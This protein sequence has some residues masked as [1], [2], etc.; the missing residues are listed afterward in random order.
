MTKSD[1]VE[2]RDNLLVGSRPTV[3]DALGA[4]AIIVITT[5]AL[6]RCGGC[7]MQTFGV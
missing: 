2:K 1:L 3:A 6:M 4:K 7:F 5:I